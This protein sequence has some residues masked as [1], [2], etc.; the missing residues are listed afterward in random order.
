MLY[1]INLYRP[2]PI[3]S[4]TLS[5]SPSLGLLETPQVSYLVII[6]IHQQEHGEKGAGL[7]EQL[8]AGHMDQ[9]KT[10]EQQVRLQ[11]CSPSS[12]HPYSLSRDQTCPSS[13]SPASGV[14]S[15]N[16]SGIREDPECQHHGSVFNIITMAVKTVNITQNRRE[17][18]RAGGGAWVP[19]E[20]LSANFG[21]G[22]AWRV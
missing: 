14:F 8:I 21:L 4:L 3:S 17:C 16:L 20:T 2:L 15:Q 7:Y 13:F 22:Q 5:G 6:A 10:N 18:G 19:S 9:Q 1:S 11:L 12:R